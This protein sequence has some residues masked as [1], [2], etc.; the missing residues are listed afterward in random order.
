M[1]GMWLAVGIG[2][3]LASTAWIRGPYGANGAAMIAVPFVSL[4]LASGLLTKFRL[5]RLAALQPRVQQEVVEREEP[6]S[7]IR[8]AAEEEKDPS[9]TIRPR[10]VRLTLRGFG[11]TAGMAVLTTVLLW[12]L[13]LVLQGIAVSSYAAAARYMVAIFVDIWALWSC[14]SFFRTRIRERRLFMNGELSQGHVLNQSETRYGRQIVYGYRDASGTAHQK[15]ATDFSNKLY[16]EMPIHIFYDPLDP[17][18]SAALEGS[19]Y[20]LT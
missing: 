16:E 13:F 1:W 7:A 3:L 10:R 17:S 4:P 15:P 9:L 11:Y 18:E 20:R 12:L 19:L 14:I 5:S 2:V 6:V 8:A